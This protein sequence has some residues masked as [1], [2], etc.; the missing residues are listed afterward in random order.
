M[1]IPGSDL[2]SSHFKSVPLYKG[3]ALEGLANRDSLP[4][5]SLYG[6]GPEKSLDTLFRGT[7]RLVSSPTLANNGLTRLTDTRASRV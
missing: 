4:Y 7:L 1:K 2:L 6:L 5:S 3:L